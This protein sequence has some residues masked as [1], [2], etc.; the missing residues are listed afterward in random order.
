[1]TKKDQTDDPTKVFAFFTEVGIIS[2]LATA[3]L[4]KALPDGVHPSH[5]AIVNHLARTGD[6]VSPVCIAAA[7]QVTKNTMTHSLK[8]LE[9][10]GFISVRPSPDDGR[11]KVV[12]L[13]EAGRRFRE[14]AIKNAVTS[15]NAILEDEHLTLMTGTMGDLVEIRKLL[16]E[17]R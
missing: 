17:N 16:D 6:G 7:M 5:F 3:R 10:R 14:Q 11:A 4:A 9:D 13:T 12:V 8:V 1:M 15:F 2:Q